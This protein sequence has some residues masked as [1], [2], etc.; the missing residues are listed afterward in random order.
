MRGIVETVPVGEDR[1]EGVCV[2][3]N[4]SHWNALLSK[5][6][7]CGV[8]LCEIGNRN[9]IICETKDAVAKALSDGDNCPTCEA[10]TRKIWGL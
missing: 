6:T 3:P 5:F 7:L 2:G 8:P 1:I 4:N 10:H 9:N